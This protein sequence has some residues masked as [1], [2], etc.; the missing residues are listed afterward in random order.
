MEKDN[1]TF[2]KDDTHWI[3]TQGEYKIPARNDFQ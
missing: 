1:F 2:S 3:H